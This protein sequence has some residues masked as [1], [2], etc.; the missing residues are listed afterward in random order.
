MNIQSILPQ[1]A[2][3]AGQRVAKTLKQ[4]A[5]HGLLP[6]KLPTIKISYANS[7]NIFARYNEAQNTVTAFVKK[8]GFWEQAPNFLAHEFTHAAKAAYRQKLHF[9]EQELHEAILKG[10]EENKDETLPYCYDSQVR[11][12]Q[13]PYI[14][15]TSSMNVFKTFLSE[16]LEK[17]HY[18][19]NLKGN[20][21]LN[22]YGKAELEKTLKQMPDCYRLY[23]ESA[24]TRFEE[25]TNYCLSQKTSWQAHY[26]ENS[27]TV[28]N[29]DFQHKYEAFKALFQTNNA[30]YFFQN[31]SHIFDLELPL[32]KIGFNYYSGN[33]EEAIAHANGLKAAMA[34]E[35]ARFNTLKIPAAKEK[36]DLKIK[37]LQ[38][39]IEY[40]EDSRQLAIV[41]D[42][43]RTLPRNSKSLQKLE[44]CYASLKSC[45]DVAREEV[46]TTFEE[47]VKIVEDVLKQLPKETKNHIK[48][49][50]KQDPMFLHDMIS[51]PHPQISRSLRTAYINNAQKL[52][53]LSYQNS[54][55]DRLI[56]L[57]NQWY[58]Y[59]NPGV[60]F[61][62]TKKYSRLANEAE[63]LTIA[64][65]DKLNGAYNP[66]ITT[67]SAY[68][69]RSQNDFEAASKQFS[70]L[71]SPTSASSR[72]QP[73]TLPPDQ[74]LLTNLKAHFNN[75]NSQTRL[76]GP[77]AWQSLV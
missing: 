63:R 41:L 36:S 65:Q 3:R 77:N 2:T 62:Q 67:L 28:S 38:Q 35:R 14:S 64:T 16:V 4:M 60:R 37:Q 10:V 44:A 32:V 57:L 50:L 5:K 48:T 75:F 70:N 40:I 24:K 66:Y 13:R 30:N 59:Q 20:P 73:Q 72:K 22:D 52:Q 51:N 58:Y 12:M 8:P 76:F 27:D 9:T 46:N 23:N 18:T 71:Y 68:G 34:E 42:Q 17:G 74:A 43:I 54:L 56:D 45:V 39:A 15:N 69:Y 25:Y 29:T 7:G 21:I 31:H 19:T 47:G 11:W 26:P 55:D 61:K 1:H 53:Q 6:E 49:R 33:A